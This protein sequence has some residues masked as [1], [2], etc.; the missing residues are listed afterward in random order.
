MKNL[1]RA[2]A[3]FALAAMF[4]GSVYA[5]EVNATLVGNVVDSSGA[6]VPNAK[7][8]ITET[9]TN[10]SRIGA[11]NESGN[12]AFS[13]VKPGIYSITVEVSGFKKESRRDVNVL[14][15]TTTRLDLSLTPG[16][17]SETVEVT[18]APA[19]LQ[20]DT[21]S[22]GTKLDRNEVASLPLISSNRNFQSLLN[23]VPGVAPVQEQHSQFFNASSSLQTEVNGQMRQGNN[24][25]IEGTDDNERTGLLQIYIPPI[26]AIQTV[27]V[28]VTDHDPEMGR[29]S[30]AVVNVLLKSGGNAFHGAGYEFLQNSDFNARSFFNPS[31]GH[32][33]YNYVGGNIGGPIKKNKLFFF[34]DYLDVL[35]HEANTNLVT[36]PPDQW[37][38]GNLSTAPTII[39]DPATG[40]PLDGTGR[41]PFAGNIIPLNRINP[42]SAAILGLIP[43]TNQNFNIASPTNNYYAALPYRKT[44]GSYDIKIDDNLTDSDKLTGRFSYSKPVIFQAPLFGEIGGDGPGGAFM[45]T[46]T[47]RTYSGGLNYDHVFSPTLLAEFRVG[48]SYYNNVAQQ[49][50]YGKADSTAIGI[51]GVNI[52]PFTSGFVNID[53]ND[54]I[55]QPMTGYS[56]SLPWVRSEAN[57]DIVNTWT[58]TKGNHSLKFGF[59]LKRL[60]DN[61]LQDQTYGARGIY[62]FGNEQTSLC[63]PT[64]V[65]ASTG[66]AN[67][68]TSP[69]LGVGNDVASYLLDVPYQLGR[70]V[71]TYFPGL[72]AWEFFA[73]VGDRWQV[74]PKLTV[75]LGLRWEFYPPATPPF[76]GSFSNYDPN[77]NTLVIAGIGNNPSNLGMVT[78]YKYFAPRTG[79]AY[80]LDEKTV[81]RA[82]FGISYTPFPDNT[83]AYNYPV[84]S[85]N[86]YTNVGDGFAVALLP[87]GQPA[88]FQQGFPLPVPVTIPS[89]G[90]LPAG[91][92]L[93]SQSEFTINQNFKNPAVYTWNIA[94]QRSLWNGLT[95]DLAYVGL[96]GTDTVATWN[97]NAPTSV[98]G[99]GTA[100]EPLNIAFGKTAADTLYWDGFSSTYHALQVKL[101]RRSATFNLTTSFSYQKA[102]DFQSG[103][104][105][106]LDWQ[107]GAQRNYARADFDRT[108][109][110]VQSYVYSLPWGPGRSQLHGPLGYVLGG[111][112]FAGILNLMSGTP[113]GTVGA[114]GSSLNT[115]GETQTANQVAPVSYPK[116]INV[117]NPWFSTTSFT[118]PTG[119]NFGT[120]GR[121]PFSGPGLFILNASLFKTIRI[122]ERVGIELRLET[123]N[124]TNTPEFSNPN[125][126]IT[127]S[128]YGYVTGT[129][130]SGTGVN[131]TG[132]GRAVQLGSK[133]T[134]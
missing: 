94:V 39:Y 19:I 96:K 27:D 124:A 15:D 103:D 101:N 92:S 97:L 75:D 17:V 57:I 79:I 100:S 44:T 32:L 69:K 125:T 9:S 86:F 127:S 67:G 63:I 106:G 76:P 65:N 83:Y 78:R 107:I 28:S 68:C 87:N 121:N 54:G 20:T 102:M 11:T 122:N 29:A 40:N 5:Q 22:T 56:A 47:Q 73:F 113:I 129:I 91:G 132:G 48:V 119:V 53:L 7:V 115:P 126:S 85:N 4:G 60:R 31:V 74:T 35:D 112:Q 42:V 51:P 25:M 118:Q 16:N 111:W 37:R 105:G 93:L 58:K 123:F 2:S 62:N 34:F 90:I 10:V 61:L 80:R 52:S 114:S 82:G 8:T 95:L 59:D 130:G 108:F 66:L 116:G 18:G 13:N 55:S 120:S 110:F 33:A 109:V 131:G 38:G 26:E 77:N 36:I 24:F 88:T 45:G 50:D 81:L 98:L 71:N 41:T 12:Y 70:D 117:G 6:I 3:L 30:G 134:F 1:F 64:S 23:M 46:G 14:V 89:N 99:G 43:G 133:I 49:S 128:T 84:R 104:D 72:R 21:A